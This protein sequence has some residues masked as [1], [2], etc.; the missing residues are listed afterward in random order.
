MMNI[1]MIETRSLKILLKSFHENYSDLFKKQHGILL[2][3]LNFLIFLKS[4]FFKI[5]RPAET[6]SQYSN[7]AQR[8][9]SF[10]AQFPASQNKKGRLLCDTSPTIFHA[11]CNA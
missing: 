7:S 3:L 8:R 1:G 6:P 9:A 4:Y 10:Q 5:Q 2:A 11:C